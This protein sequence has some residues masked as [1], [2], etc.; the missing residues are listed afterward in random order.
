[1]VTV[2]ASF[3]LGDA[4][5]STLYYGRGAGQGRAGNCYLRRSEN[6]SR[7]GFGCIWLHQFSDGKSFAGSLVTQAVTGESTIVSLLLFRRISMEHYATVLRMAEVAGATVD[8]VRHGRGM[9]RLRPKRISIA[10]KFSAAG[11]SIQGTN[12]HMGRY[13]F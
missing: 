11:W 13:P 4:V 5:G 3:V 1:M 9:H 2:F 8:V 10:S 6:R 12:S 7:R